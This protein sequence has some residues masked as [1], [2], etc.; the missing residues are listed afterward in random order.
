VRLRPSRGQATVE[1]LAMVP[2]LGLAGGAIFEALAAGAA[3]ELAG[4]AAEAGA[5]AITEGADPRA[6]ARAAVPGWGRGRVRVA[7][8]GEHVRVRIRPP[9]PTRRLGELLGADVVAIAGKAP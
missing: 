2:V 6:A 5:V 8:R 4:H 9:A 1:V 3:H 7:I